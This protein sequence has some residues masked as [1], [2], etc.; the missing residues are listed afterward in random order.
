MSTDSAEYRTVSK[1]YDG[2]SVVFRVL[3]AFGWGPLLNLGRV[4]ICKP[5]TWFSLP[6]AQRELVLASAKLLEVKPFCNVLDLC[7]GRGFSSYVL[8]CAPPQAWVTGIDLLPE[9]IAVARSLY[10]NV[11]TL[12]FEQGDVTNLRHRP[13][14]QTHRIMCLE[15]GFH[16]DR[17]AMLKQAH[18]LLQSGG[19]LLVVDFVWRSSSHRSKVDGESAELVKRTWQFDDFATLDEYRSYAQQAGLELVRVHN[20]T[21]SVTAAIQRLFNLAAWLSQFE[22]GRKLMVWFRPELGSLDILDWRSFS[23]QAKAHAEMQRHSYYMAL[24]F[25]KP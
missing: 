9:N 10:G 16:L 14:A 3:R 12:S 7:C 13:A 17:L 23:Q 19:R 15:A 8:S 24:L 5:W 25:E 11:R 18:R 1:A 4:R 2:S 6:A 20:W 22:W 21:S